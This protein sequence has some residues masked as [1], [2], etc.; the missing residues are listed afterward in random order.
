MSAASALA[1]ATVL[2]VLWL[3]GEALLRLLRAGGRGIDRAALAV[4]LGIAV[5]PLALVYTTALGGH[6]TATG[7][8]TTW[9]L[10]A[11]LVLADAIRTSRQTAWPEPPGADDPSAHRDDPTAAGNRN[12]PSRQFPP[13]PWSV[14]I[15]AL[16]L[17]AIGLRIVQ[18]AP[19]VVPAWVDGYHHSLITALVMAHGSVPPDFSPYVEGVP[20]YYHV[21]FHAITAVVAWLARLDAPAAVLAGGQTLSALA[22]LSVAAFTRRTTGSSAAAAVAAAVPVGWHFFPAYYVSWARYT[23]LCGLVLLPVA[24]L[25]LHAAVTETTRP[26]VMRRIALAAISAGGLAI[27][28]YRVLV[29]FALGAVLLGLDGLRRRKSRSLLRLGVVAGCA[30]LLAAPWLLGPFRAGVNN[31]AASTAR[32]ESPTVDRSW[33]TWAGEVDALPRWLFDI[34]GNEWLLLAAGFG[35]IVGLMR[36]R[37]AADALAAWLLGAVVLVNPAAIGL[38]SSWLVPRFALAISLWLPVSIAI[39]LLVDGLAPLYRVIV[40][41]RGRAP[42]AWLAATLLVATTAGAGWTQRRIANEETVIATQ[43][44]GEAMRWVRSETPPD[45][46]FLITTGPWHLGTW[47]GMDGGYWLPLW[48]DRWT[49]MPLSFYAYGPPEQTAAIHAVAKQAAQGD[50]LSDEELDQLLDTVGADW[51]YI[52]PA[53]L[54]EPEAWT[55]QRLRRHPGLVERYAQDGVQIFERS[56]A[57]R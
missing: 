32:V 27:V 51:L 39:G 29:F 47:R 52:G 21:G 46:R 17:L 25:T 45:A 31:L 53:S 57:T 18:A 56:V 26:L 15:S 20:F 11:V 24:W 19:L 42:A 54:D 50:A 37:R 13:D 33:F 10:L 6:W 22:A 1:A 2:V 28:H 12:A 55:A 41:S 23:Q 43:A 8:R 40:G 14:A 5:V 49:S 30:A 38:P 7:V 9:A 34:A 35:L 3:P 44:D 48:A 36:G 4:G 16:V